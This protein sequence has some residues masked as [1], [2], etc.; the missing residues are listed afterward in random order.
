MVG[1]QPLPPP[2][3]FLEHASALL[4]HALVLVDVQRELHGAVHS[5]VAA[6]DDV[7][8]KD[9]RVLGMLGW[10]AKGQLHRT[11]TVR[12][13]TPN[14]TQYK[15]RK[16]NKTQHDKHVRSNCKSP[17]LETEKTQSICNC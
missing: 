9:A 14:R 5:H 12:R 6:A 13:A 17:A 3:L 16:I 4:L 2:H 15:A 1:N 11:L 7:Q 10:D 8:T